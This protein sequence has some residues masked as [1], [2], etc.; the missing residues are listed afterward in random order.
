MLTV[1]F[2]EISTASPSKKPYTVFAARQNYGTDSASA[3]IEIS[4]STEES[5]TLQDSNANSLRYNKL[6]N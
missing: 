5:F 2:C 4:P 1:L 6:G 3:K